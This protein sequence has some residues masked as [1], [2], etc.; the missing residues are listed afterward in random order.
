MHLGKRADTV[1]PPPLP[2]SVTPS[3]DF[4]GNDGKW[5]TFFINVNSDD[6]GENGQ[7]FKV[8]ISTSSPLT[9]L[10]GQTG[11]CTSDCPAKR[12]VFSDGRQALGVG[13]SN[14]ED[15]GNY[16]VPLPYWY[17]EPTSSGNGSLAGAWGKTNVG[18]GRSSPQ[19]LVVADRYAVKYLFEDFFM[20]SF[21][22]AQGQIGPQ[23]GTLP[24]FLTQFAGE[25]N[26][27]S[28]S[29]GYT[30]GAYYRKLIFFF[31]Q[32]TFPSEKYYG[33]TGESPINILRNAL[34]MAMSRLSCRGKG[35]AQAPK[36]KNDGR[37]STADLKACTT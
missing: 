37:S 21:G 31:F 13:S 36:H 15:A 24:T 20:G 17:A 34:A 2:V 12:G 3:G 16:G 33:I 35:R 25:N 26:V 5:S 18:L 9:L 30:A 14:W 22:L 29:F 1:T 27:A 8:L 23:S 7:D 32:A 6:K 10:P 4:D 19:S 11:W 28:S